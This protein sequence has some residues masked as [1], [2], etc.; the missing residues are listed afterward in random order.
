L[1]HADLE[2]GAASLGHR[3]HSLLASLKDG[4]IW[5]MIMVYFC[6]VAAN[7][8]LTFYGPTRV[9]E[10]GFTSPMAVGWIMAAAYLCGAAGKISNGFHSDKH[11][12]SRYPAAWLRRW[13]RHRCWPSPCCSRPAPC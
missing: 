2:R 9:K 7:S 4:K 11:Q 8:S 12:E 10:V 1:V 3:E 5:L 13:V 6:I